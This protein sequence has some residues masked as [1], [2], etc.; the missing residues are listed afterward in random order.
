MLRAGAVVLLLALPGGAESAWAQPA[1][2]PAAPSTPPAAATREGLRAEIE[3]RYEVLPVRNGIVLKPRREEAGVRTIEVTGNTIAVNG[4]GVSEGVLRAWLGEQAEPILRLSQVPAAERPAVFG[5]RAASAPPVPLPTPPAAPRGATGET[6]EVE[7]PDTSASPG[8]T[9]AA[10]ESATSDEAETAETADAVPEEPEAPEPPE[11]LRHTGGSGGRV[12]FGGGIT[13]D[14]DEIAQEAVAIL[15]SVRVDGEVAEDAV[16]VGG[17]VVVNGRVGGSVV[18]VGGS[19]HLGPKAEVMGDVTSV[20]G[21]IDREEG[22]RIHGSTEEVGVSGGRRGW[23]REIDVNR[24]IWPTLGGA[25]DLFWKLASLLVLALLVFLCLLVA[26]RH[27]DRAEYHVATEPWKAGLVG[28]AAQLLFLPMLV[29]VT[30]LLAITIVGC[31]LFL[32]YPFLFVGVLLAALVGYTAVA[33]RL[34]RALEHRFDRRFGSPYGVALIGLLAIEI[35]SIL[36]R[37]VSMGGGFLHVIALM[38]LAFG[39][40]TQ[41]AAWTVGLGAMILARLNRTPDGWEPVSAPLVPTGPGIP[42]PP[43]P[44]GPVPEAL[45]LSERWDEEEAE[46]RWREDTREDTREETE[47]E[48]TDS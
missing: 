42:P 43:P 8:D 30:V 16:A 2:P 7:I 46:R 29:V 6:G 32:L 19:V 15:G 34:G 17:S 12:R 1:A 13:I 10:E 48:R 26:R 36:G 37:M 28:F 18:A 11:P 38:I 20:G 44:S 40:A 22:A 41:Y 24:G 23:H 39:F 3:A 33:H 35:W 25:M 9:S 45:P 47:E 21:A 31:A 5:L 27:V 4:E 14:K